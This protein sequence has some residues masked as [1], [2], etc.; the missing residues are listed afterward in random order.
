MPDRYLGRTIGKYRVA[1]HLG[2]GAF[3]WVYEAVDL[4]LEIPVALKILRP[5]FAGQD[6]A[7]SRF[8]KEASTAARLRHPNIVTVRDVGQVDGAAFVA[9]DLYPLTLGR[10]LT[11]MGRLPEPEVVRLG[12]GIAAALA[13]AHSN[14]VIHRDIKPDNILLDQD[15]EAV[16]ADF[17]LARA[18]AAPEALG[19]TNQVQ[20][21]PH[22]FSPEQARGK[23]L[24]G[25]SDL[26]SLGVTL[27]RAATG[28]LPFDG[29][30]W[31]AVARHHI[32]TTPLAPRAHV[33][34]LT[35]EFDALV[36]RLLA[37]E[38]AERFANAVQLVDAL[39]ALPTA[40]DHS[41]GLPRLG[42]N[43]VDAFRAAPPAPSRFWPIAAV[44]LVGL[45]I[46]WMMWD[47]PN[48]PAVAETADVPAGAVPDSLPVSA[49]GDSALA[50]P[51]PVDSL[52]TIPD[53]TTRRRPTARIRRTVRLEISTVDSA[54]IY[55]D[56]KRVGTGRWSGEV[57]A[58][59][60]L[61]LRAVVPDAP[62]SC[63]SALRDTVLTGLTGGQRVSLDLPVRGCSVVRYR[64]EPRD[65][66]VQF[67]PVDGGRAFE[68]RADSVE[69]YSL[70]WGRY[71]MRISAPYCIVF[72]DTVTVNRAPGE[73][74]V[75]RKLVC[76]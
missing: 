31:Y 47:R 25:R 61:S 15:G 8:R 26:Y 7:E 19:D 69:S 58:T 38:P 9:M 10:R 60:R 40:P 29:D 32:E 5:E 65:A 17:G 57:P 14:Q 4:D 34:E 76:S 49:A 48:S 3:S 28:K 30:D 36:M 37:K 2:T 12:I 73:A 33:P 59:S 35:P 27:Y 51:V 63:R 11:L 72:S 70:P 66:R 42:S 22:Y 71:V 53:T 23:E 16:V 24:D 67:V 6:V 41:T 75:P 62:T 20:G 13:V 56:N 52:R 43:T 39:A 54:A 55:V 50:S 46:G 45:V 1:R 64:V 68:T 21:T 74:V 18:L 44:L